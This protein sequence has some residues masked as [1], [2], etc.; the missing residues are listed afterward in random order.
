MLFMSNGFY[1]EE[2]NQIYNLINIQYDTLFFIIDATTTSVSTKFMWSD[3]ANCY[4]CYKMQKFG[5]LVYMAY[6][7]QVYL[8]I[9]VY[10]VSQDRFIASYIGDSKINKL[11]FLE[12]QAFFA[13][14]VSGSDNYSYFK[15]G[16]VNSINCLY[17]L[18][19]SGKTMVRPNEE[20]SFDVVKNETLLEYDVVNWNATDYDSVDE[21]GV[22]KVNILFNHTSDTEFFLSPV[23][24]GTLLNN[25]LYEYPLNLTCSRSGE[26]TI[27]YS[28]GNFTQDEVPSWASVDPDSGKLKL[29]VPFMSSNETYSF[30]IDA[31]VEGINRVYS[32]LVTVG[33]RTCHV[34]DCVKCEQ[35]EEVYTCK[36]CIGKIYIFLYS[37]EVIILMF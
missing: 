9:T 25:Y 20:H 14:Y 17:D 10:S 24:T 3:Y 34:R 30:T 35:G 22:M 37:Y 28:I 4:L 7:C 5:D 11:A 1:E 29:N 19:F 32:K 21:D 13:Y 15:R 6:G 23:E 33:V 8:A 26:T 31:E 27:K 18:N 2:T 16:P 12:K 36:T